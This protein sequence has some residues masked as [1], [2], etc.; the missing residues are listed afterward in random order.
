MF[1]CVIRYTVDPDKLDALEQYARA[2]IRLI[3]R[4]GG[5]HHGYFVPGGD[6]EEFPDPTFSF[7]GLGKPGPENTAFALFSF[8][9]IAAYD[10]YRAA[11]AA[12]PDCQE[13]TRR[14]E[15]SRCF[16][17]YERHFLKPIFREKAP[18]APHP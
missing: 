3:E 11:V 14:F 7:P 8:P 1:T 10:A 12:D 4:Y 2:W 17:A 15:Q 9:D 5:T 6:K 18:P 16:S 13:A